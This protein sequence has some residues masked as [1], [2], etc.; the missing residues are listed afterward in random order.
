[1]FGAKIGK[2]SKY[3][4]S[5]FNYLFFKT[6]ANFLMSEQIMSENNKVYQDPKAVTPNCT[7][8]ELCESRAQIEAQLEITVKTV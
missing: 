8:A 5:F 1:M 4:V 2:W 3:R 7:N 6:D